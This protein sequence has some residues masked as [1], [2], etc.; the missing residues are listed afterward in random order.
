MSGRRVDAK[1]VLL[2][3]EGV[4]KSSLV[5]RCAH[6][7]FRPGPYQNVS[8]RAGPATA[9]GTGPAAGRAA[10]GVGSAV[11]PG[12]LLRMPGTVPPAF[13]SCSRGGPLVSCPPRPGLPRVPGTVPPASPGRSPPLLLLV[14]QTIG[15]AFVAKVISVGDQAVTLGIWVSAG[16]GA[17]P[18]P[19]PPR[20]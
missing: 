6:R 8:D 18:L 9:T 5:E 16:P 17:V 7:R 11:L 10:R 20:C 15:A 4:G 12:S 13:R 19:V 2:G 1:V 14:F 3:Q